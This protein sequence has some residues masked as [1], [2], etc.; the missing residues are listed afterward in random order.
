MILPSAKILSFYQN[1]SEIIAKHCVNK[2]KPKMHCNGHCYLQKQLKT[3][4]S[5]TKHDPLPEVRVFLPIAICISSDPLTN[6]Y[7][8]PLKKRFYFNPEGKTT[9]YV[10][11]IFTPP[12][13]LFI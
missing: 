13:Y 9:G 8:Q 2:N 5:Q 6:H 7:S 10:N 11:S 4:K 1:Q 12:Q 3:D